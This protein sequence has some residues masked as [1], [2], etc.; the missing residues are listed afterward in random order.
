MKTKQ[1]KEVTKIA[2]LAKFLECDE[3]ELSGSRYDHYGLEVFEHGTAE[4][5]IGT[6]DEA[7]AAAVEYIGDSLWAFNASFIMSYA[8]IDNEEDVEKSITEMQGKLCES[9]NPVILAMI[10]G[11]SAIPD[12][13]DTAISADG[14]GHFLSPYDGKEGEEGEFYIYRIN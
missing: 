2:A 14:R 1:V 12:F 8:D 4:Y 3:S 11:K 5:A 13:A 10:G 7:Q 6:D 9:A